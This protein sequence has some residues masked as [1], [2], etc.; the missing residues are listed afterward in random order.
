MKLFY[1]GRLNNDILVI[2][3]LSSLTFIVS[4]NFVTRC[5]PHWSWKLINYK[6]RT[7]S[8]I[9]HKISLPI[10]TI[11]KGTQLLTIASIHIHYLTT[12]ITM[13]SLFISH[14]IIYF[15]KIER[16]ILYLI[17]YNSLARFSYYF[18]FA[19]NKQWTMPVRR[20]M[21]IL[22]RQTN[23]ATNMRNKKKS[24]KNRRIKPIQ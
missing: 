11:N 15:S 6:Y 24:R 8:E 5:W 22:S 3:T 14:E 20:K 19:C 1:S 7:E 9:C 16:W 21:D 10:S 13:Y 23:E 12:I 2:E 17:I 4:A 18:I